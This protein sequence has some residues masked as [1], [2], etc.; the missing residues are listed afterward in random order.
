MAWKVVVDFDLCESNAICMGIV[1]EVFEVRDDNFLY[2]LAG[3]PAGRPARRSASRPSSSARSRRSRS[4]RAEVHPQQASS[5]DRDRRRRRR[6][7]GARR[8]GRRRGHVGSRRRR[9]RVVEPRRPAVDPSGVDHVVDRA[10]HRSTRVGRSTGY[11]ASAETPLEVDR[12]YAVGTYPGTYV[13]PSR[14]TSPNGTS[15]AR[16]RAR[17][18]PPTGSRR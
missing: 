2:V 7:R 11:D 15:A 1:P 9:R 18:P 8:R 3:E 16:R 4:P 12:R 17:S 5:P 10:R 13:D 14:T 6:G